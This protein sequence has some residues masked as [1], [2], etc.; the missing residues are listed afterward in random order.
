M[1]RHLQAV[2]VV[3]G[4][5]AA[6]SAAAHTGHGTHGLF[7]GLAHPVGTDHLLAMMAVGLWSALAFQGPRRALGPLTFLAA[8][9]GG[10]WL[11]WAGLALPY[12]EHGIALSVLA[13]GALLACARRL[14]AAPGLCVV[15][16]AAALHGLAH[17]AELPAGAS[18][19][20]YAAGF[21][22]TTGLLHGAGLGL[23]VSL[24]AAS[25]RLWQ[26]LGGALG[27][28]GLLLLLRA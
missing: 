25:P 4:M 11:A 18:A 17:G 8:M 12:T 21:L 19:A 27:A 20:A 6:G 1:N 23:G 3:A 9:T 7:E 28:A 16:A 5:A 22:A 26:G 2:L 14:P 13:F 15:A 24:R 10:A